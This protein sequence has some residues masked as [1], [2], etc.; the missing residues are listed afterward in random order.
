MTAG[1]GAAWWQPENLF[2]YDILE[3]EKYHKKE[4]LKPEEDVDVFGNKGCFMAKTQDFRIAVL[5]TTKEN[6][7]AEEALEKLGLL[8]YKK[9][10]KVTKIVE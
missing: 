3:D 7:G 2:N 1:R 4:I 8:P 5:L 10:F 9:L 6:P